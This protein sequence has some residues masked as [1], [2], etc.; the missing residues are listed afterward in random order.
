MEFKGTKGEWVLTITPKGVANFQVYKIDEK[1]LP[2]EKICEIAFTHEDEMRA[3]A[4]LIAAAP[5]LLEALRNL[6]AAAKDDYV[7]FA[8]LAKAER[9]IEKALK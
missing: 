1:R 6:F 2:D 5:E 9:A 8:D 4:K 3:N 7:S